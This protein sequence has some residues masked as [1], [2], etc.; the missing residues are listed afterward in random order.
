M[1]KLQHAVCSEVKLR[2][3]FATHKSAKYAV[4]NWH[5][6]RTMPCGK[7]VYFGVWEDG[8]FV[9]VIIYGSGA[10]SEIGTP[11]ALTHQQICELTRVALRNHATQ[12]S[13][14][15]AI[16]L[17]MLKRSNPGLRLVVSFADSNQGHHG[18]IYQAGGW[19]YTGSKSYHLYKVLNRQVHP[20]SLHVKYGKG[21]QSIPWLRNHVDPRAERI[22]VPPKHKYVM[23]LDAEMRA[24]I[25]P[26]K[27]PYPKRAGSIDNDATAIH[28]DQRGV[29]PTSALQSL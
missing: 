24:R 27:L 28:A 16:S 19:A 21:G 2:I 11:Y 15:I 6:S 1:P 5:Y 4:E 8:Q 29:N 18:G 12:V 23:P 13:K 10:A 20:K 25:E 17:K 26:L 14:I 9:G 22:I 3:D 7:S